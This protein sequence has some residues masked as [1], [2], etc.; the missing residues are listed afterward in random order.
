MVRSKIE[1]TREGLVEK[2]EIERSLKSKGNNEEMEGGKSVPTC[3]NHQ[4]SRAWKLSKG[5]LLSH[6]M[7][8]R[9]D[10][11]SDLVGECIIK[12]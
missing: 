12:K 10:E 3:N 11:R 5:E 6:S 4:A 2:K 8:D 9:Y 1:A 7:L